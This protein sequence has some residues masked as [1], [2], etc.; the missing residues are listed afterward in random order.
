MLTF[1]DLVQ[2]VKDLGIRSQ[3]GTEFDTTIK[4]SLN[5]SL[6]RIAREA[7]WTILRRINTFDMEAE[8]TTG[9]GACSVTNA[10]KNVTVTG[11]TFITD[12]IQVGRRIYLGGSNLRYNIVTITGETT[13]TVDI[14]YDGTT[15]SAESYKIFGREEYNLPPQVGK[16]AFL[17]H[18]YYGNPCVLNYTPSFDFLGFGTNLVTE[19]TPTEYFAWAEDMV[20]R[21]PNSAS[22]VNI[23]SSSASDTTGQVTIFGTVSSYPDQETL[24]LNGTT[25]VAGS[26]SFSKIERI[27]KDASTVG[28]ITATT[29]SGNVTIAVLPTGDTTAGITYKKVRLW[30]VPNNVFPMNIWYYKMPWRM[31]NDDDVHELGQEFDEALI[32]LTVSKLR[33][34]N[35]SKEGDRFLALYSDEIKSLRKTNADKL[36]FLDTLKSNE[37]SR[38]YNPRMMNSLLSYSQLGGQYG[39]GSYR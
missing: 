3:A 36:D 31:V 14:N 11:A 32:N 19:G 29:N 38:K 18:E 35:N 21:Q 5:N 34:Q 15:D 12:G 27:V 6:F 7:N 2:Q 16:V 4:M 20:L 1:S 25:T 9:T 23:V 10:S 30:P 24:N 22:V 33:Y 39:P 37:Q 28:R 8:Y 17:W 13:L 26:K